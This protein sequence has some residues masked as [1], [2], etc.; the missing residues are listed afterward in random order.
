[1]SIRKLHWLAQ[2]LRKVQVE[3]SVMAT[4]NFKRNL[5]LILYR[6]GGKNLTLKTSDTCSLFPPFGDPQPSLLN[7]TKALYGILQICALEGQIPKCHFRVVLVALLNTVD[8]DLFPNFLMENVFLT[9][10]I[11]KSRA[12]YVILKSNMSFLVAVMKQT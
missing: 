9:L 8:L 5:L 3:P 6:E 7:T 10:F 2:G 11:T 4:Q 12:V 1:M